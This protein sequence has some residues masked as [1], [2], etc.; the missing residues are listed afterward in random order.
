MMAMASRI[1][2]LLWLIALLLSA[3]TDKPGVVESF[4]AA[5]VSGAGFGRDFRLA[6]TAGRIRTLKDFRG[7]VVLLSFGYTHCPDV[8]PTTLSQLAGVMGRLGNDGRRV[9]VLFVTLDPLRDT[10]EMLGRYLPYF[11]PAF[12]GLWGDEK[13]IAATAR[14]FRVFYQKQDIGSR[15][16]YALD[17]TAGIYAFDPTGR[18]RLFM[19]YEAPVEEIVHDVRLLLRQ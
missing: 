13:T 19:G 14:E 17:H 8:C 12:V 9:Q 5:D 4:K 6:D 3:C 18:L 1:R 10:P 15:A 2:T 7:K 16:G 11:H